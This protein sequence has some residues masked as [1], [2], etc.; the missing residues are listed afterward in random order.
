MGTRSWT[1]SC[2]LLLMTFSTVS[3]SGQESIPFNS[4]E[5]EIPIRILPGRRST[6]DSLEL[7][8]TT[9]Q[10]K[11]WQRSQ[12]ASPEDSH[13]T[14]NAQSDGDHWFCVIVVDK[15]GR[16]QPK[17]PYSAPVG[18]K[19]FI[20]T[21]KPVIRI[22]SARRSSTNPEKVEVTWEIDEKSPNVSTLQMEYQKPGAGWVRV[23]VEK[24]VRGQH[25]F[26]AGRTP[27]TVKMTMQDKAENIG[28]ATV[29]VAAAKS[30]VLASNPRGSYRAATPPPPISHT[31]AFPPL[32]TPRG[33]VEEASVSD[34]AH[35]S[36]V[37]GSHR[38][39]VGT[40]S[41]TKS[42]LPLV[43]SHRTPEPVHTPAPKPKRTW[44]DES[45]IPVV[46]TTT[47]TMEYTVTGYGPSGLGGADLYVTRD[48]G[49]TWE[50]YPNVRHSDAPRV[51][52]DRGRSMK[53]AMIVSLKDEGLYGFYLVVKSGAGL[54]KPAP[55]PNTP[56][57]MQMILDT[58]LPKAALYP[59]EPHPQHPH[60]LVL[61]WQATDK[62]LAHK[63]VTLQWSADPSGPWQSIGEDTHS[64][65]GSYTWQ[66][67]S[68]IPA[69]VYLRLAVKD[70]AG[71]VAVAQ[72][73]K[74]MLIDLHTPEVQTLRLV[75]G[76]ASH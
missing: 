67:P 9:D 25:S 27:L 26:Q 69:E 51:A 24:K 40:H 19:I 18:Q 70:T 62:H 3:V 73:P 31:P 50:R 37:T 7:F 43:T 47:L 4:R 49:R 14:F 54:S 8:Y 12:S 52:G 36:P 2:L 55:K 64:N 68:S 23:P 72:T 63:P 21:T 11:T 46:N 32:P 75:G 57:Q 42:P 6:I 15:Q 5:F 66:V 44:A 17:D 45:N 71:N 30:E 60:A 29:K 48:S 53:R 22:S 10:G 56:P 76:G 58:T 34:H 28:T 65:T 1:W 35:G 39:E 38:T 16:R 74:P 33:S 20:D 61:R 13:F 41:G 59:L